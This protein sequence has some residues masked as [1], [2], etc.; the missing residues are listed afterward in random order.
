[1]RTPK[2]WKATVLVVVLTGAGR[3]A[4]ADDQAIGPEV[5]TSTAGAQPNVPQVGAT[6]A[7]FSRLRLKI[8]DFIHVKNPGQN[9][10]VSGPLK[11]LSPLELA[12]DGYRFA[13]NAGLEIE[14][15]GDT[16]W[17][18]AAIGFVLGGLAGVTVGAE[19]CLDRARIHCFVGGGLAYG[20]L[21]AFID[22]RHKG[23]TRVFPAPDRRATLRVTP[24]VRAHRKGAVLAVRF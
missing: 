7:D 17:D 1:M 11:S 23:R 20:A 3:L 4:Q 10:E 2:R 18:G 24:D 6:P 21:G 22:W 14:R 13:P 16:I 5:P 15:A 8:G 9:V 12:I 19:G